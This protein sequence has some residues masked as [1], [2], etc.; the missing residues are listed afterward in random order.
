MRIETSE[1]WLTLSGELVKIIH[2]SSAYKTSHPVGAVNGR[3]VLLQYKTDGT[4][5]DENHKHPLDLI[6]RV[7]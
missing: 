7:Q 5:I 2:I 4:Y 3:N 1:I 6:E